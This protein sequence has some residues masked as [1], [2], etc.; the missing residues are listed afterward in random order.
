MF[1]GCAVV[2]SEKITDD[3]TSQVFEWSTSND[4]WNILQENGCMKIEPTTSQNIGMKLLVGGNAARHRWSSPATILTTLPGNVPA[5]FKFGVSFTFRKRDNSLSET[6]FV[7]NYSD[8]DNYSIIFLSGKNLIYAIRTDGKTRTVSKKK[9]KWGKIKNNKEL[10]WEIEYSDHI[11]TFYYEGF[12]E[13]KV[14]NITIDSPEIGL[15]VNKHQQ[16]T[17]NEVTYETM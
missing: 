4:H 3:F 12:P 15:Y 6:G 5:S 2:H 11:L 10:N 1:I 17:I 8:D 16:L 13:Y 14:K 7:F 9:V